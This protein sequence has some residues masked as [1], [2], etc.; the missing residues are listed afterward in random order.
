[1]VYS[2]FSTY[3]IN[4]PRSRCLRGDW[5]HVFS[6][7]SHHKKTQRFS[8]KI[9]WKFSHILTQIIN[10]QT[11]KWCEKLKP[12][13][14]II[15][16]SIFS[17]K[18]PS[19]S[20]FVFQLIFISLPKIDSTLWGFCWVIC[21]DWSDTFVVWSDCC[22]DRGSILIGG[23]WNHLPITKHMAI[24]NFTLGTSSTLGSPKIIFPINFS[25]R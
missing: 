14:P 2:Y 1:M 24:V 16:R 15:G 21:V 6:N 8:L 7:L 4:Q 11:D 5:H 25:V 3:A 18:F 22:V 20:S 23:I 9:R 12:R 19:I 10:T 17:E 13:H